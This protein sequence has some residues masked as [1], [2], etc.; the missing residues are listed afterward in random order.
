MK[1]KLE[2][3]MSHTLEPLCPRDGHVMQYEAKGIAWKE[4]PLDKSPQ[5]VASY[6]CDFEGCS[7]RFANESGYFTVVLTPEQP[8]FI[9]EPG[10][11]LLKCPE[12]NTWLY[13]SAD[14]DERYHWRCGVEGCDYVHAQKIT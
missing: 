11:N 14:A 2:N 3:E 6:H 9:E 10:I 4:L 8:Y 13:R 7:V 5:T 12:H 1:Q